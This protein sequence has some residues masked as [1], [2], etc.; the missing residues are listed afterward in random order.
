MQIQFELS[1]RI[2]FEEIDDPIIRDLITII[3]KYFGHGDFGVNFKIE[4]IYYKGFRGTI[5]KFSSGGTSYYV[6]LIYTGD[7][8][9]RMC[10]F[11]DIYKTNPIFMRNPLFIEDD[12]ISLFSQ[13]CDEYTEMCMEKHARILTKMHEGKNE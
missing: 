11:D 12:L 13:F 1:K 8:E 6:E 5:I 10:F 3:N 9:I 2:E 7:N 4:T